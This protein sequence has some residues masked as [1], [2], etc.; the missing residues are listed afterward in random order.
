MDTQGGSLER[1]GRLAKDILSGNFS[2]NDIEGKDVVVGL[3]HVKNLAQPT[4]EELRQEVAHLRSLLQTAI[5]AGEITDN[6]AAEDAMDDLDKV[7]REL[8]KDKAN[9][10]RVIRKLNSAT[11]VLIKCSETSE[12]VGNIGGLLLN[13][14]PK[15]AL[16]TQLAQS[17]FGM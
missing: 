14:T 13:I 4:Q 12:A 17:F 2:I 3:R 11:D 16:L 8:A 9:E 1:G 6:E 7:D 5:E 10:W 15:A